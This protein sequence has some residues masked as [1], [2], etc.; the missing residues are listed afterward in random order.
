MP[1]SVASGPRWLSANPTRGTVHCTPPSMAARPV[2]GRATL[3]PL[4]ISLAT[5]CLC[6]CASGASAQEAGTEPVDHWAL[7]PFLGTGAYR[8]DDEQTIWVLEYTVRRRLRALPADWSGSRKPGVELSIPVAVG[9]SDFDVA[10]VPSAL[11]PG[12]VAALT[13]VPGLYLR[14]PLSDRFDVLAI[15]NLGAGTR[16]DGAESALVYRAGLRGRYRFGGE[17]RRWALVPGLEFFGFRSDRDR[18]ADAM[19]LSLALEYRRPTGKGHVV[20]HLTAAHYLDTLS[21][22]EL[23]SARASIG[24]DVELGLA[25]HPRNAIRWWRLEFERVGLAYRRGVGLDD[26]R[27]DA[28]R[29]T[30]RSVFEQ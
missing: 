26:N 28:V 17:A 10:R 27:F 15:A 1:M 18:Q 7:A 12:N 8:V 25:W 22:S 21:F 5:A 6:L 24:N 14:Y 29:L 3:R 2:A 13:I 11:R 16:F 30:F 4:L 20:A 19:P 23:D 9:L